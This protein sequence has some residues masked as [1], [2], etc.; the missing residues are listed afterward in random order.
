VGAVIPSGTGVY[1][2]EPTVVL[3]LTEYYDVA[4]ELGLSDRKRVVRYLKPEIPPGQ[5]LALVRK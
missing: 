1:L 5:R 3:N 4:A 2:K